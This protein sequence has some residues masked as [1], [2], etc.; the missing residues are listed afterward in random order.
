MFAQIAA[1]T[2]SSSPLLVTQS[3]SRFHIYTTTTTTTTTTTPI[4]PRYHGVQTV[5]PLPPH[6]TTPTNHPPDPSS[7]PSPP[8]SSPSSRSTSPRS[9]RSTPGP[10]HAPRP[11]ALP[12]PTRSTGLLLL[13]RLRIV[14]RGACMGGGMRGRGEEEE[15]GRAGWVRWIRGRRLG[16]GR[17]RR[18]GLV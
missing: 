17:R 15:E 13:R 14:I 7:P 18:V 6:H 8:R 9:S 10:P 1:L 5:P 4:P 12:A 11:T 3:R 16:W 2:T